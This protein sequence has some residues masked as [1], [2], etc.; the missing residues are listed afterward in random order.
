MSISLYHLIVN[1]N[2]SLLYQLGYQLALALFR[3]EALRVAYYLQTNAF[4]N[5]VKVKQEKY[6]Y[7]LQKKAT[8]ETT[9]E[10]VKETAGRTRPSLTLE[11]ST[12]AFTRSFW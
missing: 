1:L 9:S 10:V 11:T 8:R 12:S 3:I 6:L 4:P 5:L 7:V 2:S